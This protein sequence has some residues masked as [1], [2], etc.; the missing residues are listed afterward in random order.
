MAALAC[1]DDGDGDR[2]LLGLDVAPVGPVD[3]VRPLDSVHVG[4][5]EGDV[6]GEG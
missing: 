3:P 4:S 5:F 2:T 6:Y 1:A